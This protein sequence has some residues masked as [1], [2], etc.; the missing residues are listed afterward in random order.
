MGPP[1]VPDAK[2]GTDGQQRYDLTSPHSAAVLD[3]LFR[4]LRVPE[5]QLRVSW[6]PDTFVRWDNRVIQHFA[7]NDYLPQR[8]RMGRGTVRG[9]AATGDEAVLPIAAHRRGLEARHRRQ[10]YCSRC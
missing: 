4:Q 8:R 5:Y 3:F 7:S 9:D 2:W 10:L 1:A 6:E